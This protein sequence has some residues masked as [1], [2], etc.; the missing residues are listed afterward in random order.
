MRSIRS[1]AAL[2]DRTPEEEALAI[3]EGVAHRPGW[4]SF[5]EALMSMP[6]VGLDSDFAREN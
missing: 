1:R 5:G 3:L 2:H 4:R 6:D